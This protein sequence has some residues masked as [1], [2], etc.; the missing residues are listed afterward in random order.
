LTF[1]EQ[2]LK[3]SIC[4]TYIKDFAVT[5]NPEIYTVRGL[6]LF[7]ICVVNVPFLAQP[8]DALLIKPEGL[9][10]IARIV[11]ET[12]F[13]GKFFVLFSFLFGWGFAQQLRA[14]ERAGVS[15]NVLFLRRLLALA[16]IGVAHAALVFFGDILILYAL[17]GLPL[18]LLQ[19]ASVQLLMVVAGVAL[20]FGAAAL[21]V[22]AT[23]VSELSTTA[24]SEVAIAGY[25]SGFL[26]SLAQR[27]RDWPF[28][29]AF[30]ALFNGPVA[31]AAFC[32]GLATARTGFFEPGNAGYLG[33]RKH[34][35]VL[36]AFALPLNLLYSM[37]LN[38][39]LGAGLPAALAFSSLAFAGPALG[40]VYLFAAI[41][42]S[43]LGRFRGAT[44]AAG[45]MSL[46]CY[47]LEG[48]LAGLLFN[49][50]GL[51]LYGSVG[52]A[53]CFGIAVVIYTLTHTLAAIWLRVFSQGPLEA[54]LS[55]LKGKPAAARTQT[56]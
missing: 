32:V 13:Q 15:G 11:V 47:V 44:I 3:L 31:F 37:S 55:V 51:G 19:R 39:N 6:A 48:I 33:L 29:F 1:V 54:L 45:R 4:S 25:R 21:F 28:A 52:A 53:A 30:N 7:G 5:R 56:L 9:D 43:R 24:P 49:G 23:V 12:L 35:P 36:L 46:T 22:I 20:F 26:D 18:L 14:A 41:E 16:L 50:Y 34:V 38:G 2:A 27:V 8:L 42:L 40:A 17:L 10:W